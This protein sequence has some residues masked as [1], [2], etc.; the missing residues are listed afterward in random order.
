MDWNSK[1]G[2][3]ELRDDAGLC[4]DH[5]S[6]ESLLRG[7]RG[8]MPR[9]VLYPYSFSV[10]SILANRCLL[11]WRRIPRYTKYGL[12]PGKSKWLSKG[13]PEEMPHKSDSNFHNGANQWLDLSLSPPVYLSSPTALFFLLLNTL[14]ASV[15]SVF[16][17]ILFC[18]A[19]GPWPMSLTTG[20]VT[21][22]WC[23][24]HGDPTQ[25]LTGNPNP[26]HSKLLQAEA[27]GDRVDLQA[28]STSWR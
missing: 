17:E 16:V 5:K 25:S 11:T 18:K 9:D 22:I 23:F 20:L 7:Q 27:T 21:K 6:I 19:K 1:T 14:L 4:P 13:D 24:Q 8:V 10:K 15:L 2:I 26:T 12:W 3:E 28:L